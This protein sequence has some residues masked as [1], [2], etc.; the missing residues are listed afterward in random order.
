[1]RGA[2]CS[3]N[4]PPPT[5][6]KI[7][8]CL[9]VMLLDQSMLYVL[10]KQLVACVVM[11]VCACLCFVLPEEGVKQGQSV[12]MRPRAPNRIVRGRFLARPPCGLLLSGHVAS[13]FCL[14]P[15]KQNL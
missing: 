9:S 13:S 14:S 15:E 7:W 3:R 12:G 1:M 2:V 11:I 4:P 8:I 6:Q 5:P 10:Y